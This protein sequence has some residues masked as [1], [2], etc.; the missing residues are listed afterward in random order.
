MLMCVGC[1]FRYITAVGGTDFV[2]ATP[3][4]DSHEEACASDGGGGFSNTFAIP[5]YQAD[6]VAA[7][8]TEATAAGTL[9]PQ[10]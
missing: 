8:I 4:L 1:V 10:K 6:A 3:S 2:S 9:P 7:Y 5:S